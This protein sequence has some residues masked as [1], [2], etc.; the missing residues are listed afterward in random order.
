MLLVLLALFSFVSVL[1]A[2]EIPVSETVQYVPDPGDDVSRFVPQV[3]AGDGFLVVWE[4]RV[5]AGYPGDVHIR[6]YD[7]DGAPRTPAATVID[8]GHSAHVVWTGSDYLVV[9]AKWLPPF[10]SPFPLPL[11]VAVRVRA[12][13][14]VVEGSR[15]VVR[16]GRANGDIVSLVWTGE[17]AMLLTSELDGAGLYSLDAS[18]HPIGDASASV[19]THPPV[20]IA[21]A[22]GAPLYYLAP[23]RG[24]VAAVRPGEIAVLDDT[25]LGTIAAL[26]DLQGAV[27]DAFLLDAVHGMRSLVWDGAAWEGVYATS[28]SICTVRFTRASDVATQCTAGGVHPQT[29][30]IA[31]GRTRT[32]RAWTE[33]DTQYSIGGARVMTDSG[34][35]SVSVAKKRLPAATVDASGL[36]VAWIEAELVHIGGLANDGNRR[37]E[38]VLDG[39]ASLVAPA[40]AAA[41]TQSLV[42]W[43][44]DGEIH[45]VRLDASGHPLPP[46]LDLG[47]GTSPAI[48]TDGE[49]WLVAWQRD[50]EIATT[51]VSAN[52]DPNGVFAF[53][54]DAQPSTPS[55]TFAD[56]RY[57]I[58]WRENGVETTTIAVAALDRNGASISGTVRHTEEGLTS[59]HPPAIACSANG[60]LVTWFE[61]TTSTLLGAALS[62][63]GTTLGEPHALLPGDAFARTIIVAQSDGTFRVYE[64]N[65]YAIVGRDASV[66]GSATWIADDPSLVLGAVL[67]F[68]ANSVAVYERAGPIYVRDFA[69]RT[70]AVRH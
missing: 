6:A 55:V 15:V 13:G 23:E 67:P 64:R 14:S 1:H 44:G 42:V 36:L 38:V 25:V 69:A 4:D 53:A 2:A 57:L 12:D 26:Y 19:R 65:R 63:D 27:V 5:F 60:C 50:G 51:I 49:R 66:L 32:F 56:G 62:L 11:F 45:A 29:P 28:D 22:P 24:D 54:S 40:I 21:A 18:G 68:R 10:G 58:V 16:E 59:G 46:Y 34:I 35:A 39:D 61:L 20:A 9:Y 30:S 43:S 17:N 7:D 47:S 33:G 52:G 48:A 31:A 70:R 41:G 8:S 3:A 37:A